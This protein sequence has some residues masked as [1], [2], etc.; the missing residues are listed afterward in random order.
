MDGPR[1]R[2]SGW[3]SGSASRA[4][5]GSSTPSAHL[6]DAGRDAARRVRGGAH[7]RRACSWTSTLVDSDLA[8]G[9]PHA[10]PPAE[11]FAS[12]MQSLGSATA[13]RMVIYDDSA[14]KTSARGVVHLP[15]VRRARR[16]AC[17]TAGSAKW[18]AEGRPLESG[19][20]KRCATATSPPGRTTG[21]VRTKADMLANIARAAPSRWSTR[22]APA[23]FTGDEPEIRA[24][25]AERPH[26]RLAQPAATAE[27]L[28]PD[29]TFKDEAGLAPAFAE[30]GIDLDRPVVT[31][32]GSGDDRRRAAVRAAPARQG[33]HRALRRQ[34]ERMG[35]RSRPRPRRPG[36]A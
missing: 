12:R 34:L 25:H 22:A 10:L 5:C 3:R 20:A 28:N 31:T 6:P 15:D 4:T 23:R 16:R 26:P 13:D 9:R 7:P 32:C 29:G 8:A 24:G 30:A 2:P 11:K 35:R 36:P 21:T 1:S 14:V 18:K 27:L 17:S 33:R 19:Q